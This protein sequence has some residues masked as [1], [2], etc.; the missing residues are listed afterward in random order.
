MSNSS[1]KLK[2]KRYTSK[3]KAQVLAY[4]ETVNSERGRGGIT[5]AAKKFRVTP[6]TISNWIKASGI[7]SAMTGRRSGANFAVT[8]RRLA[9]LHDTIT[10][11]EKELA[12]LRRDYDALKKKL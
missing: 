10:K 12:Q 7:S 9:D 4:V 1:S 6:L 3:E 2:G 8:L 11:K 5:A